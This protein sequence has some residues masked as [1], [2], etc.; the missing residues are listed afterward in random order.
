MQ[1]SGDAASE[2]LPLG[3]VLLQLPLYRS[4]NP[5]TSDKAAHASVSTGHVIITK[6]LVNVVIIELE[7]SDVI[8]LRE[9][10]ATTLD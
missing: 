7:G 1:C 2:H 4:A 3:W 9:Q 5:A 6:A 10:T 8:R